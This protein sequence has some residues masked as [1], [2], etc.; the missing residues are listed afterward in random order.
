[1]GWRVTSWTNNVT[2]TTINTRAATIT[3]ITRTV[4]LRRRSEDARVKEGTP[5]DTSNAGPVRWEGP[6][7]TMLLLRESPEVSPH[8]IAAP[9]RRWLPGHASLA[10][11]S[12]RNSAS[13]GLFL[14]TTIHQANVN[15]GWRFL[16]SRMNLRL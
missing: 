10:V 16:L 11:C 12:T 7:R 1:V 15:L 8:G 14:I 4:S 9:P 3:A 13:G 5:T 2:V 6:E